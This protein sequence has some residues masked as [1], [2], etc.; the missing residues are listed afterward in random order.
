MLSPSSELVCSVRPSGKH[1]EIFCVAIC[2]LRA[3]PKV[4]FT[5]YGHTW[6]Q[7]ISFDPT[8]NIGHHEEIL[9]H[10]SIYDLN[11]MQNVMRNQK[12][13]Y[14][15]CLFMGFSRRVNITEMQWLK[16]WIQCRYPHPILGNRWYTHIHLG[17]N[18]NRYANLNSILPTE[19]YLWQVVF[20]RFYLRNFSSTNKISCML[21]CTCVGRLVSIMLNLFL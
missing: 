6:A 4:F 11:L 20:T 9:F 19:V 3:F 5:Q 13:S 14:W 16:D 7:K 10:E 15:L 12:I 8:L 2:G 21:E 18:W 1:E 17:C